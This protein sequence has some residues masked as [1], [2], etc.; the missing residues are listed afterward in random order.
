MITPRKTDW[1]GIFDCS[2]A[3]G[4]WDWCQHVTV[5]KMKLKGT[6]ETTLQVVLSPYPAVHGPFF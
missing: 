4:L 5:M 1:D 6:R 2:G 3:D